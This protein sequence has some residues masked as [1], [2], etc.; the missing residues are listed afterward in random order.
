MVFIFISVTQESDPPLSLS[1]VRLRKVNKRSQLALSASITFWEILKPLIIMV[2]IAI[3][4][5][6]QMPHST[7]N[8]R[9]KLTRNDQLYYNFGLL[10]FLQKIKLAR[11]LCSNGWAR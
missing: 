8:R 2:A 1:G 9:H 5:L 6:N 10:F 4:L 11:A 3:V 7:T